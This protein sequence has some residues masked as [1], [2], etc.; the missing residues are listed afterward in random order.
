MGAVAFRVGF[1]VPLRVTSGSNWLPRPQGTESHSPGAS[2]RPTCRD[3]PSV[4]PLL[5]S[6]TYEL[7]RPVPQ[8]TKGTGFWGKQEK[9]H[10][11]SP[12]ETALFSYVVTHIT[13]RQDNGAV[14]A[15]WT[16]DPGSLDS[17]TSS[18]SYYQSGLDK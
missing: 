3:V 10:V 11:A 6:P 15:W 7:S 2:S 4:H 18:A 14:A 9:E 5:C 8:A 1:P 12:A 16:W 13:K 17:D